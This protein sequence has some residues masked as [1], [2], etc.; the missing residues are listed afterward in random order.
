MQAEEIDYVIFKS[1]RK[2]GAQE[3]FNP[4]DENDNFNEAP[5]Y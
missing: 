2:V 5:I 4:Y 1:G 3:T